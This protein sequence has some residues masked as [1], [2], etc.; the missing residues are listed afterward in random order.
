MVQQKWLEIFLQI[1]N[2]GLVGGL[3][4]GGEIFAKNYQSV[5]GEGGG[6]QSISSGQNL[7]ILCPF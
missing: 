7:T 3:R 6:I 2:W 5:T 1:N 4:M